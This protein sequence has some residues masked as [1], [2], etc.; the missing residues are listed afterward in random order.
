MIK[1]NLALRKQSPTLMGA[2][3]GGKPGTGGSKGF[4]MEILKDL[5]VRKY[6]A[7]L[8]TCLI[9]NYTLEFYEEEVMK[10]NQVVL[11][12]VTKEN[13]KVKAQLKDV[14]KFEDVKKLLET[15]EKTLRTKIDVIRQLVAQRGSPPK[16]LMGI[17]ASIPKDAWLTDL[18]VKED[19]ATFKGYAMGLGQVSDFMRSLSQNPFFK[20]LTLKSSTTSKDETGLEV[21]S[22]E[23]GAK[24]K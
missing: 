15:D 16:L 4:D 8:L 1:I 21:A 10:E 6:V 11:D 7:A 24:R 20:D 22:F 13:E 5:P 2:A 17:A 19:N 18:S 23:L 3:K 14:K 9:A 12:Q